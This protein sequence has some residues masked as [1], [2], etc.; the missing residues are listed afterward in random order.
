MDYNLNM[1]MGE[2]SARIGDRDVKNG[3][4]ILG[5]LSYIQ[6]SLEDHWYIGPYISF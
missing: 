6:I 2:Q 3:L 1:I 5:F 4:V